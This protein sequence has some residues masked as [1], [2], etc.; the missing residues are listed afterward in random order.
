EALTQQLPACP[1]GSPGDP[2]LPAALPS[3]FADVV[4]GCLCRDPQRRWAVAGLAAWL[5]RAAPSSEPQLPQQHQG[6]PV[7]APSPRARPPRA[8]QVS[9]TPAPTSRREAPNRWRYV[10]P[11]AAVILVLAVLAGPVLLDRSGED[12]PAREGALEQPAAQPA[13][14]PVRT[15]PTAAAPGPAAKRPSGET[16]SGEV[17]QRVMP[18]VSKT[19]L[20]TVRG[21]VQVTV[22]VSVD[23]SGR[24]ADATFETPGPSRYFADRSLAAARR[25]EFRAPR[26]GGQPVSSQWLLRFTFTQSGVDASA[27]AFR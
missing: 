24:V 16:S 27:Q 2:P 20:D 3:E 14:Q 13:T 11:A 26:T 9:A 4:R 8:G 23:A 5:G 17:V 7:A 25:W 18:D 6:Q 21:T 19:A 1:P 12:E 10:L 22:R 15:T